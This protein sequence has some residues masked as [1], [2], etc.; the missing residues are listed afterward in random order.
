MHDFFDRAK[1][2]N[3]DIL[4]VE[5]AVAD[6][7]RFYV[8]FCHIQ[9]LLA[10]PNMDFARMRRKVQA[11]RLSDLKNILSKWLLFKLFSRS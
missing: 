7:G 11:S 8:A 10:G 2:A 4:C 5:A 1:A 9:S 3:A 6:T